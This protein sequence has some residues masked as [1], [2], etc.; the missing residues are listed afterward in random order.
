MLLLFA[1]ATGA[2]EHLLAWQRA[3]KRREGICDEASESVGACK[4]VVTT[5]CAVEH[6]AA[7]L[8]GKSNLRLWFWVLE[9]RG[10][11]RR[12]RESRKID[13]GQSGAGGEARGLVPAICGKEVGEVALKCTPTLPK[14]WVF[15]GSIS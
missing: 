13:S 12:P 7:N 5:G 1:I 4:E 11:W 14:M 8:L 9:Y 6:I 3:S 2:L 10:R 15:F